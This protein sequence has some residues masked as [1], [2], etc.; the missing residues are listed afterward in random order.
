MVMAFDINNQ[1]GIIDEKEDG[2]GSDY[3]TCKLC[4][5]RTHWDYYDEEREICSDCAAKEDEEND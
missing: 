1:W 5:Q 4:N 2:T 3:Y